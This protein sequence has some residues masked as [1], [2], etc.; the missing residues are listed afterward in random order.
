VSV[1]PVSSVG[2]PRG[3]EVYERVRPEYPD[4]AVDWAEE[5]L[6]LGLGSIVLDLA[7]GTGKLTRALVARRLKVLAVDPSSEML[8]QLRTTL[9]DLEAREGTA[10]AIPLEDS[11][12]DAVT[13]GQAFHWFDPQPALRE[14]HRVL[15]P[16]GG[17]ALFRNL[18]KVDDPVQAAWEEI[19]RDAKNSVRDQEAVDARSEIVRSGLFGEL[20]ELEDR[21]TQHLGV[22]EYV[23]LV[24]SRSY[25]SHL[26]DPERERILAEVRAAAE[27]LGE[28]IP[29]R[30]VTHVRVARRLP[31]R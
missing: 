25:V 31:Q 2:F 8:A 21:W 9:P 23:S 6:G 18:R 29:F 16:N 20:E 7:A 14:I 13:V 15:R 22:D 24:A 5:R 27:R 19:V 4:R 11:T 26:A 17:L 3:A 12:V 30:Y 10:E 1:D 28:P